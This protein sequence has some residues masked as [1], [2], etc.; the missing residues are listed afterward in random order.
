MI[1]KK[2]HYCW[3]GRNPM[4]DILL[5]CMASWEKY[6]PGYEIIRWDEDSYDVDKI[7][8]TREAYQHKK[9]AFVSD[10]ARFDILLGQGGIYMDTDVELLKPLDPF[11]QHQV[12]TGFEKDD[13]VAPG[14]ILGAQSGQSVIA[15]MKAHYEKQD[16]FHPDRNAETVVAIMTALLAE[17]GLKLD[18]TFQE[19]DGTAVY[20][21]DYFAPM[22]FQSNRLVTTDNT[23]SIHHYAGSWLSSREKVKVKMFQLL[24][25][26]LGAERF[27]RLRKKIK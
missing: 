25:N 17:K 26:V 10:Y 19:V 4:P 2:I 6:L 8:F 14:L 24:T 20:P 22:D 21:R 12:F 7:P 15:E 16:G 9:Y 1:P 3:F 23:V 5:K 13:L 27:A 18:N 11:L